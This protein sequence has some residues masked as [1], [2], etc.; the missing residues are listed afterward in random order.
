MKH[1]YDNI[2]H[3]IVDE[4]QNFRT[5]DGDWYAKA[6]SILQRWGDGPGVLCIF[7]DYFQINHLS[8][9]GL[10][11][12]QQ[13]KPV[14]KLTRMLRNGDKITEYLQDLMQ[15]IREKPPP[16]VPLEA[17]RLNQ[18]PERGQGVTGNLE[19]IKYM[20]LEQ[21]AIYVAEKCQSLWES[22]YHPRDVAV[23][24]IRSQDVERCKER[25]LLAMRSRRRF[26]QLLQEPSLPVQVREGLDSLGNH[27]VLDSLH[28]FSDMERSI[29][30]GVIPMEFE[31][32]ISYNIRLC[33]ASRARTH[34]YM[35]D[36]SHR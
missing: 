17:L 7:L 18:E 26:S 14:L 4:A 8:C 34:L 27:V 15:Q 32:S 12:L 5:E 19:I 25:L 21:M 30:F 2:Q 10:P 24:F 3:I 35:I 6:K 28:R 31:S 23:L 36:L 1:T 20:N 22:G 13:Q 33:M 16:N 29:V 11:D 9:T